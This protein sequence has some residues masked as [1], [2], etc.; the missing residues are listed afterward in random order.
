MKCDNDY[1]ADYC[2]GQDR[3]ICS[4]DFWMFG[5]I[6][7]AAGATLAGLIAIA[8]VHGVACLPNKQPLE[9]RGGSAKQVAK[10]S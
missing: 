3:R 2:N 5:L 6:C 4:F 7:F 9:L 1:R 10:D 8:Y